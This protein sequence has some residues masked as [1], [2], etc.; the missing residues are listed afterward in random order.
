MKLSNILLI[1]VILGIIGVIVADRQYVSKFQEKF[2]VL[3]KQRI[4]TSNKLATAKIIH[5]NLHHVRDLVFKNM[6]FPGQ[7]DTIHHESHLFDFITTCVNDL[8]LKLVSVK[9]E[10]PATKDRV[11]TYTYNI[12]VD[13]DFF[14]FGELCAKFENSRRIV[15]LESFKVSLVDKS[16]KRGGGA[17]KKAIHVEMTIDTYRVKKAAESD[18]T[19][20]TEELTKS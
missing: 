3:E 20:N 14:K 6:D 12:K 15:S 10:R 9:P 17:E 18:T 2:R 19:A 13:G 11:T 7:E 8:K 4:V 1:I 16:E 5:E